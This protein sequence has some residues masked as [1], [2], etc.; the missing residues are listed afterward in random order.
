[1]EID[2]VSPSALETLAR[3][4]TV[5]R[6]PAPRP[7]NTDQ[8]ETRPATEAFRVEFSAEARARQ[9]ADNAAM[10]EVPQQQQ[11]IETYNSAGELGG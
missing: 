6:E 7:D 1:M 4:E 11:Q 9:D 8:T 3:P 10:E 5:N 2:N